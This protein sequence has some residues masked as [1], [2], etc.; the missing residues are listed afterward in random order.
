MTRF[1]L[2][3]PERKPPV[4][5]G[6]VPLREW[7][8]PLALSLLIMIVIWIPYR[9]GY[10]LQTASERFM[11]LVGS[12]AIDDNNVY[13]GLMRQA[14]EGKTLFTNNFTPEANPPALFNFLYL[15]LGQIGRAH[16]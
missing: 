9:D 2:R 8:F 1:G 12:D 16:V 3:P 10:S 7:I 13:L 5:F 15:A 6:R 14:A 4:P 11:G